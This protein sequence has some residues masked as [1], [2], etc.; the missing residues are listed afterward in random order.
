VLLVDVGILMNRAF[1]I[2]SI[3][4][5]LD[6]NG[7]T[8]DTPTCFLTAFVTAFWEIFLEYSRNVFEKVF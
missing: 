2:V 7:I 6:V 5:P 1:G 4:V 3:W 8:Q